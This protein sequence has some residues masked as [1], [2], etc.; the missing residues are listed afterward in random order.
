MSVRAQE[1]PP[2]VL[3]HRELKWLEMLKNWDKWISKRFKKVREM[4]I[5]AV[6]QKSFGQKVQFVPAH[7]RGFFTFNG[8][9]C[10][11]IIIMMTFTV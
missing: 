9:C 6:F 10:F 1:V 2:E 3:R 4:F 11:K 5:S 7:R 8:F